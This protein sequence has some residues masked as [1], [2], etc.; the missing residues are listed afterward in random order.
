LQLSG[1]SFLENLER[2][3]DGVSPSTAVILRQMITDLR[4]NG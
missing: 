2:S 3:V 1:D 4:Q